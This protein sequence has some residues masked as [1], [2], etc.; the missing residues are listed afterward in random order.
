MSMMVGTELTPQ[1]QRK[2][3]QVKSM[4]S[5]GLDFFESYI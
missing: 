2:N 5:Y 1:L 4:L 3:E